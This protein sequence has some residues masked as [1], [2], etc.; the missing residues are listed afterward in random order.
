MKYLLYIPLI[1]VINCNRT[2][3]PGQEEKVQFEFVNDTLYTYF[4]SGAIKCVIPYSDGKRNGIAFRYYPNGSIEANE[5]YYQNL[6]VG[7]AIYYY[8]NGNLELYS[9]FDKNSD[10]R[11]RLELD[12]IGKVLTQE[13]KPFYCIVPKNLTK[14]KTNEKLNVNINCARIPFFNSELYYK[15]IES[16]GSSE[17]H[18]KY[19]IMDLLPSLKLEFDKTGK[20]QLIMIFKMQS[21]KHSISRSDTINLEINVIK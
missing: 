19:E 16:D 9:L 6:Q 13:G 10:L 14:L 2:I 15:V 3:K 21:D 12:S 1:F 7:D 8:E 18:G 11:Y 4:Q 17:F 5:I 20:K